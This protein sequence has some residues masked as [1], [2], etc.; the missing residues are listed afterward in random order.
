VT[1]ICL[2]FQPHTS[3]PNY[4]GGNDQEDQDLKPAQA[5]SLR[6]HILKNLSQKGVGIVAED[7]N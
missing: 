3:N 5:N 6:E 4:S 1:I 2:A 7:S